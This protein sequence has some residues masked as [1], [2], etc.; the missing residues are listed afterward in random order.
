[1][2]S[3]A[4]IRAPPSPAPPSLP[5]RRTPATSRAGAPLVLLGNEHAPAPLLRTRGPTPPA[6]ALTEHSPV[7]LCFQSGLNPWVSSPRAPLLCWASQIRPVVIFFCCCEFVQLSRKLQ[8]YRLHPHVHAFNN[9]TTV[10]RIKMI[11]ICKML[12]ISSSFIICYFHPC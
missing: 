5:R 4:W 9:S 3:R 10:H 11:Y 8:I 12:R 7:R 6:P 1:M 2:T